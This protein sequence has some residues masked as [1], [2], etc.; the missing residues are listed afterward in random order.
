MPLFTF[1]FGPAR[2]FPITMPPPGAG[3]KPAFPGTA[4]PKQLHDQ[5]RW[6]NFY[7]RRDLLGFP[8]KAL[9]P[10]YAAATRLED[11]SVRTESLASRTFPY[12][13]H[14]TAHTGYWTNPEVLRRTAALIR[15]VVET[16]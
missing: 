11:I 8:L 2:V 12:L 3:M 5:A 13:S 16:P 7:S 4:L 9:N 6:L 10:A 14:I 1:T 15:E